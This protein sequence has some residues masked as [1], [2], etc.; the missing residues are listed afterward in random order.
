MSTTETL[1]DEQLRVLRAYAEEVGSG[2]K[3]RLMLDWQR[4]GTRV[5]AVGD[6]YGLLHRLRNTLGPRWLEKFEFETDQ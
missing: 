2:W 4:G 6:Q 5:Y 3:R 1:T